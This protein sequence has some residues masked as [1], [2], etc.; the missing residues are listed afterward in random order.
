[1]R[2]RLR[3]MCCLCALASALS[4]TAAGLNDCVAFAVKPDG[5]GT[6]T[7]RCGS[8]LNVTYCVDNPA[9]AKSCSKLPL[10]VT[11]LNRDA[12]EGIASYGAEGAGAVHWAACLYPEAAVEWTPGPGGTFACRKTCV[13]C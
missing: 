6:L 7:N 3:T 2:Q 1:M 5:Q 11:T 9:S 10:P 12:F 13:M 8:R 4:A